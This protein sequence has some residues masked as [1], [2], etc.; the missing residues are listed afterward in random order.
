[1][2]GLFGGR[3]D[4]VDTFFGQKGRSDWGL[5]PSPPDGSYGQITAFAVGPVARKL[6]YLE[7]AARQEFYEREAAQLLGQKPRYL[8]Q[9][10]WTEEPWVG[11]CYVGFFGPGGGG[12]YV[13]QALY[14]SLPGVHWA[15]TERSSH[16]MGYIEGALHAAEKA[17][18]AI[19]Q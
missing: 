3:R 18:H 10:S 13:G 14:Q 8:Y 9:K 6:L 12:R 11:G 7:P 2:T 1:M 16:W 4:G 15:G 19:I 5:T 17:A